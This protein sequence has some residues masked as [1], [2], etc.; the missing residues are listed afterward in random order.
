MPYHFT[1]TEGTL[2]FNDGRQV[3]VG[4]TLKY[5]GKGPPACCTRGMHS[6]TRVIDALA[7]APGCRLWKVEH[8]SGI[9]EAQHDKQVGWDRRAVFD[10][11]DVRELAINFAWW[12]A[13][14]VD[15]VVTPRAR[16]FARIA[17]AGARD[18]YYASDV[19][20][21]AKDAAE[22]VAQAAESYSAERDAQEKWWQDRLAKLEKKA[23]KS[24]ASTF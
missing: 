6:S 2:G 16:R 19:A 22:E 14:R 17:A 8:P 23:S 15:A 13:N 9:V 24:R 20:Y 12:C 1:N 7:H 18:A 10:Y 21:Y 5:K 3:L 11:G 4:E